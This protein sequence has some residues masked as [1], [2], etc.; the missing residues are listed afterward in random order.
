[1]KANEILVHLQKGG[2][3]SLG[4]YRGGKAETITYRD[5]LTG[6]TAAF[7]QIGHNLESGN[8]MFVLQERMPDGADVSKF[9]PPF[10]KGDKVFVKLETVERVQGFLRATGTMSLIEG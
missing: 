7:S 9:V 1:M 4:E 10:K 6:K 8:D 5:K 3:F 2:M